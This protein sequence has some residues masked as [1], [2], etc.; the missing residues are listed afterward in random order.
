MTIITELKTLYDI[1]PHQWLEETIKILKDNRFH[2][3]DLEN[4]IEELEALGRSE[5]KCSRESFRTGYTSLIIATILVTRIS[6]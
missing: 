3:L 5:K 1:D 4:L 6:T 2:E